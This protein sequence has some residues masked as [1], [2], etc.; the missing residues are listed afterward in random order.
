MTTQQIAIVLG[1][2]I[3]NVV[4]L[5][6]LMYWTWLSYLLLATLGMA[7]LQFKLAKPIKFN[8]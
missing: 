1:L 4:A 6:S 2:I 5:S 8:D 7:I 3:T